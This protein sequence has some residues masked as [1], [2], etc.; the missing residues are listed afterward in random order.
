NVLGVLELINAMDDGRVLPF[1]PQYEPL[2]RALAAQA[3]VAIRNA[4]LEDLSLKDALTDV[5]NR[6]YF[7]IR[8]EEEFKR[9]ARFGE[10]LSLVRSEEHTSELQSRSDLV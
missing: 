10:P 9:H 4:R 2:V 7:M 1:D 5:Y 6:R 8:L 3:A